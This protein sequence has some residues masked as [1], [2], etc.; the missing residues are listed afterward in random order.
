[1]PSIL[2]NIKLL[3]NSIHTYEKYYVLTTYVYREHVDCYIN[4]YDVSKVSC[5]ILALKVQIIVFPFVKYNIVS[6]V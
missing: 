1:M 3:Y 2:L 5:T 6:M 4:F